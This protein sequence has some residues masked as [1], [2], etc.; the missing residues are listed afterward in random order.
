MGIAHFTRTI[1]RFLV[2]GAVGSLLNTGQVL[3]WNIGAP[4]VT[5]ESLV[6]DVATTV[7]VTALIADPLVVPG[8][9]ILQSVDAN[10]HL[11]AILGT[12]HDDGANGDAIAG[13]HRY[14][15]QTTLAQATTTPLY[16]RVAAR[17]K[18]SR[19]R[20]FSPVITVPVLVSPASSPLYPG[21]QY[22]VGFGPSSVAVVDVNGD[23]RLDL[24]TANTDS[25]DVSVLLGAGDGTF[26]AQQ[27]FAVGTYPN[28]VAVGD[29]NGDGRLDVVTANRDS[30][31]VSVLLGNGEGAFQAQQRFVVG[32]QWPLSVAVADVNGDGRLDVVTANGGPADVA[33]LLG[34][35]DGT[36]QPPQRFAGGESPWRWRT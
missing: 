17:F 29:V 21:Q 16:L 30:A 22:P 20:R 27:R 7:T 28:S 9:V 24:V 15:I 26:Q 35:G 13:D 32:P 33:V 11:L 34:N 23:G 36:F 1:L 12:L 5:P 19:H 10:G 3:A 8:S 25:N 2:F 18:G 31:D 4:A 14:T 6:V